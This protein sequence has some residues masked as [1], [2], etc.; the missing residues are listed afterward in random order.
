M[1]CG[2]FFGRWLVIGRVFGI[3]GG[4]LLVKF[5]CCRLYFLRYLEIV[6]LYYLN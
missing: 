3:V 4:I 5:F 6:I 1:I 2:L